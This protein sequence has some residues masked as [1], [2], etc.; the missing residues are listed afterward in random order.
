MVPNNIVIMF[1]LLN[2]TLFDVNNV[3]LITDIT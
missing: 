1:K 2:T 3:L